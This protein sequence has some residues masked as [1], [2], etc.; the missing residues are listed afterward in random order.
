VHELVIGTDAARFADALSAVMNAPGGRFGLIDVRRAA[1]RDGRP[2]SVGER[3]H[4]CVN[5][6]RL[7]ERLRPGNPLRWLIAALAG[8]RVGA[9]LEEAVL[10]DFAEIVE[11]DLNP[12]P[13]N[14]FRVQYR[15]LSGTPMAGAST[16]VVEPLGDRRCRFRA[17]F[18]YQELGALAISVL[19]RFGIPVHDEVT[20]AQAQL[21]AACAGARVLHSTIPTAYARAGLHAR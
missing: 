10:A 1:E 5:L 20:E 6:S 14:A 12:A 15:Y 7:A 2:F 4:G 3:F 8:S 13:G 11:I 18:E 21:A 19:H 9:W 17:I 16:F